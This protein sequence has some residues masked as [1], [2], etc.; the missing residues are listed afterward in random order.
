MGKCLS[1]KRLV[2]GVLVICIKLMLFVMFF[3]KDRRRQVPSRSP[4]YVHN[5]SLEDVRSLYVE[6]GANYGVALFDRRI[7]SGLGD[8]LLA[9]FS[10][11]TIAVINNR[12]LVARWCE[13]S[14]RDDRSYPLA[15][16]QMHV[17]LPDGITLLADDQYESFQVSVGTDNAKVEYE[18]QELKAFYGYDGVPSLAFRAMALKGGVPISRQLFENT[19]Y[20]WTRQIRCNAT[21]G[22]PANHSYYVLHIRQGDKTYE[23]GSQPFVPGVPN[24]KYCTHEA[25]A[26]FAERGIPIYLVSDEDGLKQKVALSYPGVVKPA[27]ASSGHYT[28][29]FCDLCLM[30]NS[31][32]IIQHSPM[33]WSALS[34][35][36]AFAAEIPLMSTWYGTS[37]DEND[38]QFN[39]LYDFGSKGGRPSLMLDCADLNKI[40]P[41]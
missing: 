30:M 27:S 10:A 5:I 29:V 19:Y 33:G 31:R 24:Q 26:K 25:I 9:I 20:G 21:C 8:R 17:R 39:R 40:R 32:G 12:S 3:F 36:A 38:P 35:A 23:H 34:A 16:L 22:M 1:F 37:P 11:Y 2:F 41:M 6:P 15:E 13:Q 7:C 28:Q 18:G 4:A 14:D